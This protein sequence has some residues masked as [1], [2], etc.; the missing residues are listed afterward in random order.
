MRVAV[1][2]G[3][4]FLG[5]A[6]VE[7][8]AAAGHHV[9]LLTRRPVTESLPVGVEAVQC[10]L[11]HSPPDRTTLAAVDAVVHLAGESVSKRWTATWKRRIVESR[12]RT[13]AHLVQAMSA[14]DTRP[15]VFVC[16]SAIGFYG[17]RGP[18]Y[19]DEGSE[20]GHGFLADVCRS[21]EEE[22]RKAEEAGIR[23]VRARIGVVLGMG[24][25]ALAKMLRPFRL[26][27]GGPLGSGEQYFSWIHQRDAAS[28]FLHAV[29]SDEVKGVLNVVAPHPVKQ[30][31]F[32]KRLARGLGR[33]GFLKA[34]KTALRIALGEMSQMLLASQR[35]LPR[36]AES[37][38]Y[39]FAFRTLEEALG[40]ILAT[41]AKLDAEQER[42]RNEQREQKAAER[43]ARAEERAAER[44]KKAEAKE[45][46]RAAA[47]KVAQ[48]RAELE[49]AEEHAN[50]SEPSKGAAPA[51]SAA[52]SEPSSEPADPPSL[53]PEDS[54]EGSGPQV[55]D[56]KEEEAAATPQGND[57][58]REARDNS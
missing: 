35:V 57:A 10:D 7:D 23:V 19:L 4:G 15:E 14:M 27:L 25:G 24:G 46:E 37:T 54:A 34:P 47:V 38:G 42:V 52:P 40:D 12:T 5:R 1:T 43:R 3:T 21:W 17:D 44:Q 28:M 58:A 22:A 56:E 2:G 9:V 53:T 41:K 30:R 16:A 48:E 51:P 45:R 6:V 29:E 8:L 31:E 20:G 11:E 55:P 39:P 18:A 32:A 36:V 50:V 13:T 49:S 26:G 33:P